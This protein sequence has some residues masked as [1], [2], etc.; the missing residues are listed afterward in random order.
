MLRLSLVWIPIATV[1]FMVLVTLMLYAYLSFYGKSLIC[2]VLL[3][4]PSVTVMLIGR[5]KWKGKKWVQ[6]SLLGLC[7][8]CVFISGVVLMVLPAGSLGKS[9]TTD[10]TN[11]RDFDSNCMANRDSFFQELFPMWPNYFEN[12]KQPD[13]NFETKYLSASYYYRYIYSFD[14][15]YDVYAE[16]L[17]D[18]EAFDKEVDRVT[19]LFEKCNVEDSRYSYDVVQKGEYTCIMLW[20]GYK[21]FQEETDNYTYYIFAY[22]KEK[23]MVRYICCCSLENGADQP[24][25]LELE[26]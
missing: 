24:Y 16:W 10:I 1:V 19:D 12:K 7:A 21:P 26:W 20:E 25:Y 11:Y 4:I 8:V 18:K 5:T 22:D 3:I 13:G 23:L 15:T 9:E 14:Y 2:L 17:L 6:P